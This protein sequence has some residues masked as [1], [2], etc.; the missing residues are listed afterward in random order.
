MK[1][2]IYW[3]SGALTAIILGFAG[4]A[5]ANPSFLYGPCVADGLTA[6]SITSVK[7]LSAGRSTTT[8]G[9]TTTCD[10]T[11]TNGAVADSL[12]MYV[13]HAAS[14]S[15]LS[16]IEVVTQWSDDG[17]NWYYDTVTGNAISTTTLQVGN[18]VK[19][20]SLQVSTT[21]DILTGT[22]TPTTTTK[23]VISNPNGAKYFRAFIYTPV[24]YQPSAIHAEVRATKQGI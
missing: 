10:L 20:R 17:N 6:G 1:K 8:I 5:Y 21:T 18:I 16:L 3:V 14:S 7:F 11:K 19:Y 15:P 13:A 2:M 24:G 22:Q 12:T 4:Y 23:I 9:N